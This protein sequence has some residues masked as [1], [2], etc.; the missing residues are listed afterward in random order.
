MFWYVTANPVYP[1]SVAVYSLGNEDDTPT[2]SMEYRQN[3]YGIAVDQNDCRR[4]ILRRY[5]RV[6]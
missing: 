6:F 4:Q 2:L 3:N 1:I 5:R